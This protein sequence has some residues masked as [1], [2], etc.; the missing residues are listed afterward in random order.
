MLA[1]SLAFRL[2]IFAYAELHC[3]P[4]PEKFPK[5]S[6]EWN[7]AVNAKNAHGAGMPG[8]FH[9]PPWFHRQS[10]FRCARSFLSSHI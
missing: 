9:D 8:A 1:S 7:G 3:Q 5:A 2:R 10:Y 6:D 4:R